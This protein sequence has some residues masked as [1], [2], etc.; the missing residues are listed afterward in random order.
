MVF[1][2][3]EISC[4][5]RCTTCCTWKTARRHDGEQGIDWD[6]QVIWSIFEKRVRCEYGCTMHNTAI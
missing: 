2:L 6:A 1:V 5:R 3:N 4:F